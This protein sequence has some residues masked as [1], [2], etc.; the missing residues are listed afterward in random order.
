MSNKPLTLA[1]SVYQGQT[2]NDSLVWRDT[3]NAPV[4]LT[5][6]TARMMAREDVADD[7]PKFDWSDVDG[8]IVLGGIAGSIAFNVSATATAAL[9]ATNE[10]TTWMYDMLL[11]APSGL[12]DRLIQGSITIYPA[13]TRNG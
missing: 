7:V 9:I 10:V 13:V 5:G 11:T 6:Y 1:L 2:F 4:D 8:E 12:S 3:A